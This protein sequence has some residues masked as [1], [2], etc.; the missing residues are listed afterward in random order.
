MLEIH[1]DRLVQTP[2]RLL[3]PP[4]LLLLPLNSP[5]QL[6]PPPLWSF[7]PLNTPSGSTITVDLT[8]SEAI[9]AQNNNGFIPIEELEAT[10]FVKATQVAQATQQ[11]KRGKLV[12][13][14]ISSLTR[15]EP[16]RLI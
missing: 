5:P 14:R 1:L 9:T 3:L 4:P 13:R 7:P 10:Q 15:R 8:T 16:R 2:L 12:V 6:S 11:K